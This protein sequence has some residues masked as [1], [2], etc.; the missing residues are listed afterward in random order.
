MRVC[1]V[2]SGG[3]EHAL[4]AALG[5]TAA[6]TV[7]PGN[8]GMA[9]LG[10]EC[11][12]GVDPGS[13]DAD[14]FVI[15]PEAKL[16]DGLADRLRADGHLVFGPGADGARLEG[17]KQW[18]KDLLSSAGVPTARYGAFGEE[19]PAI[20][21]LRS[22]P[23]P[24]VV[25]TDGLAAGKGV[26]VTPDRAAA[27]ADVR[28]KLSGQAF[29]D[30]GRT[31]VIEEYLEGTELSLMAICDGR[32][33]WP[34]APAQDFKR[35]GTG[36]RGPNTGGMGAYSPVPAA[37]DVVSE[38]MEQAVHPTLAELSAR[39][40]DY[41]GV[42]YAG[43]MLTDD[44]PRV[45]EFNVRFGDPETQVVLPRWEGDVAAT[46]AAAAG[47]RLEDGPPA[48]FPAGPDGATTAAV[49]VVLAAPGYPASPDLG[50]PI[51]GL[52]AAA[53]QPGVDIYCAGVADG[54][55]DG[56]LVTAGGRVLGVGATGPDLE[57]ARRRAYQ[58]IPG[59]HWPGMHYRTDIAAVASA[60]VRS[61][62]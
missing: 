62:F 21:F 55:R 14:L 30:A 9:A 1:V 51:S 46:L 32:T 28:A 19:G 11:R 7:V 33:A 50:A 29:G 12:P 13:V 49:C 37:A 17:S 5:R 56:E 10:V 61:T 16:V 41:R 22:L 4:A 42:L 20:D 27:E 24:W 2:G 8:A 34:L 38:V 60:A 52:V 47:G 48:E 58:A 35:L 26:L 40:I 59:L 45:L 6:V 53:A 44:G 57:T 25:K 36:D 15:G 39:G 43:L 23:G 31:V 18:M 3:R 54:S